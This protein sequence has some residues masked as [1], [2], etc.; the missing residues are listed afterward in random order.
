MSE[1]LELKAAHG[2]WEV[3]LGLCDSGTPID[4]VKTIARLNK[5]ALEEI[6]KQYEADEAT[7]RS[8]YEGG[9]KASGL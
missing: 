9:S 4:G 2:I 5:N 1:L 8:G 6:I 3:V 7:T